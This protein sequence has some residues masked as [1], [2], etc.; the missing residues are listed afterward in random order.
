MTDTESPQLL[1]SNPALRLF[2]IMAC[3]NRK[4]LTLSALKRSYQNARSS[5]LEVHLTLFDD[6][7]SDGTADAATKIFP[8]LEIISGSGTAYWAKSMSIAESHV[9]SLPT[10]RETDYIVWIN[11]DVRLD[12]DAF[13]RM[14]PILTSFPRAV[15]TGAV[16]DPAT[17]SITYSGYKKYGW[18]PLHFGKVD[19]ETY[20]SSI[21]TFNG[22]IVFVPVTVARKLGGIDGEFSHAW[23]DIDYGFRCKISNIPMILAPNT[24]GTCSQNPLVTTTIMKEW[25]TFIG[26][27]GGG[28]FWSL[29]RLLSRHSP[30]AWFPLMGATYVLWWIRKLSSRIQR[31]YISKQY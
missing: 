23:A 8:D 13:Q 30:I 2:V 5:G 4:S 28:H 17:D 29:Y 16:R 11:D 6:G 9:L 18:H 26:P 27:K 22:N 19:P 21:D 7:S 1:D 31:R 3:H 14:K 25:R 15:V 10:L 12:Q 20:P 24:F